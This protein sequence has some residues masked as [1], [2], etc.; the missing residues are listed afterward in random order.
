M[1]EIYRLADDRPLA[2]LARRKLGEE[3]TRYLRDALLSGR[4][5]AGERM[6]VQ[7]L[8][9]THDDAPRRIVDLAVSR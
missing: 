9:E 1:S 6:A 5:T 8:A 3:T 7:Q 2:H 4:Y